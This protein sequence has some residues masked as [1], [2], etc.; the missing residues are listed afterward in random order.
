MT[1]KKKLTLIDWIKDRMERMLFNGVKFIIPKRAT[2]PLSFLGMLTF[3]DFLLLGITG[4]PSHNILH[5][6]H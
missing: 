6:N 3:M 4:G 1:V 2:N 5:S